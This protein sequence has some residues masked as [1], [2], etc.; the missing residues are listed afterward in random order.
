VQ[1]RQRRVL[2][3]CCGL[4]GI[5]ALS[6]QGGWPTGRR[7]PHSVTPCE[8]TS[9]GG[10]EVHGE[11]MKGLSK[12]NLGVHAS[13]GAPAKWR[14]PVRQQRPRAPGT[15]PCLQHI[16]PVTAA[17]PCGAECCLASGYTNR[18]FWPRPVRYTSVTALT[19]RTA[20]AH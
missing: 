8:W 1:N 7:P 16:R 10:Y 11:Y 3:L 20:A 5:G 18:W 12:V 19:R 4:L 6:R 2:A 17:S 9:P 15:R 14:R 13:T